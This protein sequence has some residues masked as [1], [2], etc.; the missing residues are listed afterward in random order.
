MPP[1]DGLRPLRLL[2]PQGF[3]Q[4]P[5]PRGQDQPP[6]DARQHPPQRRGTSG[7]R[8]R[9]RRSRPAPATPRRQPDPPPGATPREIGIPATATLLP[10]T[11]VN[12]ADSE[13]PTAP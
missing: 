13:R 11:A 4:G 6:A 10:I 2:F 3:P 7:D 5:A 1:P 9:T 8:R 12:H